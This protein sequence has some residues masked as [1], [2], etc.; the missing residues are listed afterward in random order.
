MG[1]SSLWLQ[2]CIISQLT[3]LG[4]RL[5]G[6]WFGLLKVDDYALRGCFTNFAIGR[7]F[8][9]C[10]SESLSEQTSILE[11]MK[12][13]NSN[14][15]RGPAWIKCL[16]IPLH[17]HVSTRHKLGIWNYFPLSSVLHI[18]L[19]ASSIAIIHAQVSAIHILTNFGF[20]KTSSKFDHIFLMIKNNLF[21]KNNIICDKN[22]IF[23]Y[24]KQLDY[25]NV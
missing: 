11:S 16:F 25:F 23:L 1:Y 9:L 21:F 20:K 3:L 6:P 2:I 12:K 4:K 18:I 10:W 24:C 7:W 14:L 22:S 19:D 8:M 13:N 15:W 17:K 5:R